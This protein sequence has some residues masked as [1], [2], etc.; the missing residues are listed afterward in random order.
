MCVRVVS[1]DAV[2][3]QLSTDKLFSNR[4]AN[5]LLY[6]AEDELKMNWSEKDKAAA[7]ENL[8]YI[9][10]DLAKKGMRLVVIVVPDKSSAYRK[11]F[12]REASMDGYPNIF[13]QLKS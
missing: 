12:V 13:D 8:K 1:G 5:R 9:Q 3:V 10:D 6:Y 7:V 11:Y 4:K 2:N